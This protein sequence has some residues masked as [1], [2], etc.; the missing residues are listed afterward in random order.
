MRTSEAGG[1][2]LNPRELGQATCVKDDIPLKIFHEHFK[3]QLTRRD[4]AE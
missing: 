2:D 3:F 4:Y 1:L